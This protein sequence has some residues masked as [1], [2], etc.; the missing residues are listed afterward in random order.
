MF[1]FMS[2]SAVRNSSVGLKPHELGPGLVPYRDVAGRAIEGLT[3]LVDLIPVGVARAG[4][5]DEEALQLD[6]VAAVVL[7]GD[8][9]DDMV[10][11]EGVGRIALRRAGLR[12]DDMKCVEWLRGRD[13]EA[14]IGE[15]HPVLRAVRPDELIAPGAPKEIHTLTTTR[16]RSA[17]RLS[18]AEARPEP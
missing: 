18:I 17:I 13:L 4:A 16:L 11:R 7:G 6:R 12:R 5:Q 2:A 10:V 14:R 8:V 15:R 3:G 1:L 9:T